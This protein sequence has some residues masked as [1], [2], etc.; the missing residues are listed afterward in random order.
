VEV[1]PKVDTLDATG[2]KSS[3]RLSIVLRDLLGNELSGRQ[4]QWLTEISS[5]LDVDGFGDVRVRQP[6]ST[7]S[8]EQIVV[9]SE[10]K[11]DTA[12]IVIV[13]GLSTFQIGGARERFELVEGQVRRLATMG[14]SSAGDTLRDLS[15]SW[16]SSDTTV[17]RVSALGDAQAMTEGDVT[18][19][20]SFRQYQ[21]T[22]VVHVSPNTFLRYDVT[23][24]GAATDSAGAVDLNDQGQV[25]GTFRTGAGER[26]AFL[27]E[28]GVLKDLGGMGGRSGARGIN[29]LG[30]VVG[31]AQSPE[32]SAK[33]LAVRWV[34]GIPEVLAGT[35]A[36]R[37]IYAGAINDRGQ[38]AI[39]CGSGCSVTSSVESPAVRWEN[40]QMQEL[41]T[42]AGSF[43]PHVSSIWNVSSI[44]SHGDVTGSMG[45]D[46]KA[47]V[48]WQDTAPMVLWGNRYSADAEATND[49]GEVVGYALLGF[50]WVTGAYLWQNGHERVLPGLPGSDSAGE[51]T[52]A[53]DLNEKTEI[54]GFS[55][56]RGVIWRGD[57]VQDLSLLLSDRDWVIEEAHKINESG[58]ILAGARNLPSGAAGS[59]LLT[60]GS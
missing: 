39:R 56:H 37:G 38:I 3:T 6:Y 33:T 32:D 8:A 28:K 50:T 22:T 54:V 1:T 53:L 42:V 10:G 35:T 12:R 30:V 49:R 2:P 41:G 55:G 58:Q 43:G 45:D 25:V 31:S 46:W 20:A 52:K 13:P 21:A 40:G 11:S 51:I 47:A 59:V 4:V 17:L 48:L 60:P 36:A 57:T 23:L 44:N 7:I 26:H 15:A 16:A 9:A 18:V 27:W 19:T 5:H 24:I 34:N 14:I 29:N